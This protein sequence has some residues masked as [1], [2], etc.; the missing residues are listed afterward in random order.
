MLALSSPS[1]QKLFY[2]LNLSE[3]SCVTQ[4]CKGQYQKANKFVGE[5]LT[6]L[7]ITCNQCKNQEMNFTSYIDHIDK[8]EL[9]LSSPPIIWRREITQKNEE[10][11]KWK[12]EKKEKIASTVNANRSEFGIK[13]N[14]LTPNLA[15]PAKMDLYNAC[16]GVKLVILKIESRIKNILF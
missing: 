9:Y 1:L 13:Y 7:R 16:V 2:I 3:L 8:C 10:L 15:V 5:I 12:E 14:L 4:N 6:N 11:K